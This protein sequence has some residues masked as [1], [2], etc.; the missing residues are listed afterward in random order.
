MPAEEPHLA[1]RFA[2]T[3]RPEDARVARLRIFVF[4][5]HG[6]RPH[7]VEGVRPISLPEDRLAG[8]EDPQSHPAREVRENLL[9][10]IV[11]R[12]ERVDQ[13]RRLDTPGGFEAEP[14]GSNEPADTPD[15]AQGEFE[16][17][18]DDRPREE[19]GQQHQEDLGA[20]AALPETEDQVP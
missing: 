6:S 20:E 4:D 14:D 12:R 16:Q 9:G 18:A 3:H 19:S 15:E 13:L 11:E 8:R 1:E 10:K 17:A 2:P 7:D 5:A